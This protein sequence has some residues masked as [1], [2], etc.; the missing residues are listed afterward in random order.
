M[1]IGVELQTLVVTI[2]DDFP[3]SNGVVKKGV[4]LV[5][6]N[7]RVGILQRISKDAYN[8]F[9][10]LQTT[11]QACNEVVSWLDPI[12]QGALHAIF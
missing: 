4:I 10:S 8:A 1:P 5:M 9:T 2:E 7:H 3:K 12:F 11:K 6:I